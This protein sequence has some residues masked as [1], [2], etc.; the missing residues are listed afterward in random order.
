M[1]CLD[2]ST[3]WQL[4]NQSIGT[5][6]NPGLEKLRS[7]WKRTVTLLAVKERHCQYTE[8]LMAVQRRGG[9]NKKN[10]RFSNRS[11]LKLYYALCHK[12]I[13]PV[14][15]CVHDLVFEAHSPR[16]DTLLSL[17]TQGKGLVLPQIG[18]S[19]FFVSPRE[20]LP[21]LMDTGLGV[22]YLEI[23]KVER[24]ELKLIYKFFK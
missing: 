14:L 21:Q 9:D 19:D 18:M 17:N 23:W 11:W 6:K 5:K 24:G 7:N 10:C 15:P 8:V 4:E 20:A 16:W 22:G 3:V 2:L 12:A 1:R 13:G